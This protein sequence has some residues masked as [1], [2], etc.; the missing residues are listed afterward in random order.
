MPL[1]YRD[2]YDIYGAQK[3]TGLVTE[4]MP[5]W[6]RRMN[7]LTGTQDYAEG[8]RDSWWRRFSTAADE[9]FF[10]PIAKYTTEPIAGGIGS[11]FGERGA[12][13]GASIGRSLPRTFLQTV[14]A[15]VGGILAAP[16]TG[17]LSLA[18]I[19]A[20]AGIGA[21]ITGG[22]F[23]A[24][25]YAETGSGKAALLSG[26]AAAA[27]PGVGRLGESVAARTIGEAW[28]PRFAGSQAGQIATLQAQQFAESK[29]LGTDYE[30]FSPEFWAQQIPFTVYEGLRASRAP[31]VRTTTT[32]PT[33]GR[34]SVRPEPE[35]E[36]KVHTE[37]ESALRDAALRKMTKVYTN[38]KSTMKQKEESLVVTSAVV[39]DAASVLK[40][41]EES[42]F[43]IPS[44]Q[45]ERIQGR[46]RIPNGEVYDSADIARRAG[47][48]EDEISDAV[49]APANAAEGWHESLEGVNGELQRLGQQ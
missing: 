34:P 33:T 23:G 12:E 25:T 13:I 15:I 35:F 45:R 47:V 11:L 8:L 39:Q 21:G 3:D 31:T 46:I 48:T 14:P 24:Q 41:K 37:E 42:P 16:E 32:E 17:G 40:A 19:P 4:S 20:A 18:A 44:E 6:S 30:P 2:V 5:E 9:K 26:A 43:E 10:E 28:L 29:V 22:L 1:S 7:A 38:P 36:P 49:P 27:L